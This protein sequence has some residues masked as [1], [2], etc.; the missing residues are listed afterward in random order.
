[1]ATA[2]APTLSRRFRLNPGFRAGSMYKM[3]ALLETNFAWRGFAKFV[4]SHKPLYRVFTWA[5]EKTKSS[6]LRLSHVRPVRSADHGIRLPA[7]LPQAAAQR[8]LRRRLPDGNCEVYPEMKC[9]WV[10]AY[11]RADEAGHVQDLRRLVRPIDQRKWG[12]S[13]WINYWRDRD[14]DLW[15][16]DD[17]L[18]GPERPAL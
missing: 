3:H 6:S 10:I 8:P 11:E 5:E 12:Q 9:V 4:E 17:G 16:P 13:S 18:A 1:M 14:E 15:T 7:D 2:A